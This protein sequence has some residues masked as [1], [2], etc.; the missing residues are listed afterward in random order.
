MQNRYPIGYLTNKEI[1]PKYSTFNKMIEFE[2]EE[3]KHTKKNRLVSALVCGAKQ[4]IKKSELL[5]R[6]R[7]EHEIVEKKLEGCLNEIAQ[8]EML[9]HN[10]K[11]D[12]EVLKDEIGVEESQLMRRI[13]RQRKYRCISLNSSNIACDDVT[14]VS[15]NSV[16]SVALSEGENCY[17]HS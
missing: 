10:T 17:I 7:R 3:A 8:T 16:S 2:L 14:G 6:L 1:Y 5:L 15:G 9:I 12:I 4:D 13:L 11:D